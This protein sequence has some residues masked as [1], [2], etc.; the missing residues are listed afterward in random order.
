MIFKKYKIDLYKT[1]TE[2]EAKYP[3]INFTAIKGAD[4]FDT[5]RNC[6]KHI[7]K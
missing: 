7:C 1:E 5:V 2:L 3:S 4:R 6:L